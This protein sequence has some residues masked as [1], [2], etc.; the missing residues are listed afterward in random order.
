MSDRFRG[1]IGFPLLNCT[2]S[3]VGKLSI[4]SQ[5]RGWSGM[6]SETLDP[7]KQKVLSAESSLLY[8]RSYSP[9]HLFH[10]SVVTLRSKRAICPSSDRAVSQSRSLLL[11]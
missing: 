11:T 4:A 5:N 3:D 10:S 2:V 7:A 8:S 9:Y 1:M 6:H